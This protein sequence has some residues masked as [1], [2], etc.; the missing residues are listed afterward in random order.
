MLL[1]EIL[2]PMLALAETSL[3][4][5]ILKQTFIVF[6]LFWMTGIWL[7]GNWGAIGIGVY[8]IV[9][10]IKM[11]R[12]KI[13]LK[14]I[15][16]VIGVVLIS[17]TSSILGFF[18]LPGWWSWLFTGGML[19]CVGTLLWMTKRDGDDNVIE[20]R[21]RKSSRKYIKTAHM[22]KVYR[23]LSEKIDTLVDMPILFGEGEPSEE[24]KCRHYVDVKTGKMYSKFW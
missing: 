5:N 3:N 2:Q 12:L 9:K 7:I 14:Y 17:F 24:H 1:N 16:L 19:G 21:S 22:D 13:H 11:L 8:L 4:G 6:G 10:L 23:E 20:Q 18:V 15:L